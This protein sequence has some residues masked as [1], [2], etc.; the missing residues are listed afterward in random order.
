MSIQKK[1]DNFDSV[2]KNNSFSLYTPARVESRDSWWSTFVWKD[3]NRCYWLTF[4][5]P[6][7]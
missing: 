1:V 6:R 5:Q 3:W 2:Q 7:I 4:Y